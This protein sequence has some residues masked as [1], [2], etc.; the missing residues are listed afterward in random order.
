[1]KFTLVFPSHGSSD[2]SYGIVFIPCIAWKRSGKT[3]L[4]PHKENPHYLKGD[5][6]KLLE[7][8]KLLVHDNSLNRIANHS[9][10]IVIIVHPTGHGSK[11]DLEPLKTDIVEAGFTPVIYQMNPSTSA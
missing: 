6:Q 8:E 5:F 7:H 9:K 1:M 4:I 10:E 3:V 2:L 11:K